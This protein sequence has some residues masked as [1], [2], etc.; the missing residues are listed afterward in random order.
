MF[1]IPRLQAAE[2][3]PPLLPALLL[4]VRRREGRPALRWSLPSRPPAQALQHLHHQP[5]LLQQ[6]PG[7]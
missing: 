1:D 2:Q 5:H 4:R 3:V 7:R 6:K